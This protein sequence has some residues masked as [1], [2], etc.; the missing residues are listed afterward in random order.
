MLSVQRAKRMIEETER[1]SIRDVL[2]LA[3]L[4]VQ[5]RYLKQNVTSCGYHIA[6]KVRKDSGKLKG[7]R[8]RQSR[9]V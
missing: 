7:D 1:T 6:A 2:R 5:V 9:A 3:L 8:T 4:L